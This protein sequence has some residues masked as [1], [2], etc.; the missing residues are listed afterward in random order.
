MFIQRKLY[1]KFGAKTEMAYGNYMVTKYMYNPLNLRLDSLVSSLQSNDYFSMGYRY[2][3][4]GN[5]TQLHSK[6]I[7]FNGNNPIT[8]TFVYDSTDQLTNAQGTYY[9]T[10][11]T[12]GNTGKIATYSSPATPNTTFYYPDIQNQ[13]STIFAPDSSSDGNQTTYYD[14]GINGSLRR[15][16]HYEGD[17]FNREERG[18]YYG[19]N[20]FNCMKVYSNNGESYGY[21]GYDAS[22]ERTYKMN[23]HAMKVLINEELTIKN[24]MLNDMTLYPN[25]YINVNR[26]GEYTKHYYADALR[27]ASKIGSGFSGNLCDSAD[28]IDAIYPNY[29]TD[30]SNNQYTEMTEE[31]DTL[32]LGDEPFGGTI[33]GIGVD[34]LSEFCELNW[35]TTNVQETGLFYYHPDHLGSTGMVT[36]KDAY[37]QQGFL[38]APFGEII[39]EYGWQSPNVPKYA[40]NAKELDEE[41]GMY[42][43]SARY[44]APPTFI[45]RDPMFEKYPSISPYTY[46]ANNPIIM[47]DEKGLFPKP[48]L[49]R[50]QDGTYSFKPAA[51]HLLSLVSQ[52]PIIYIQTVKIQERKP[53]QY[54]PLYNIKDDG[55][56]AI[57]LGTNS[58]E[59]NITL[60]ENYF[61][62]NPTMYWGQGYGKNIKEWLDLTS[63]EVTHIPQ[64]NQKGGLLKYLASFAYE[65]AKY[66]HDYAPSEQ[67]PY[68]SQTVF[69]EFSDFVNKNFE[70][71]GI[72]NLFN[73]TKT[74]QN[75]IE[76]IDKWWGAFQEY[77]NQ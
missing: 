33:M 62:D 56:G 39:A 18:E 44:Y 17:E 70:E 6:Y 77:Q 71:N 55:G 28:A 26:V 7:C 69:R 48:I 4:K 58:Y 25:G 32:L 50:N 41:N 29:L 35:G 31:L 24:F 1:N 13:T 53:G 72:Q 14:F 42:Y 34:G 9:T 2:D 51:A 66:G 20:A 3:A 23:L 5:V 57:T 59:A 10:T 65:Y 74:E 46:C 11:V 63:H 49:R 30:R 45:S 38:Y 22:G 61:E 76:I 21:Y 75:K 37:I 27:I 19:F 16:W 40:F 12:Y 54:R 47:I 60:T 73:S 43:Y 36:D 67:A 68:K 15:K 52:V 64:I 8:Q